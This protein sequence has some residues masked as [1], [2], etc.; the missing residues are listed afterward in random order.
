MFLCAMRIILSPA[1]LMD[2]SVRRPDLTCSTPPF[3]ADAEKLV[4][5]LRKL[6]VL[7]LEEL[8]NISPKIASET[9][10]MLSH[11]KLPHTPENATPAM[12]LFRGEVY[13]GLDA[14][15]LTH[16]D[17]HFAQR[18]LII[19]SGL[20]GVLHALDLVQPYRLM[21]GTS[22]APN[23]RSGSLYTYWGD[24][25]ANYLNKVTAKGETIVN[26]ASEEYF[27]VLPGSV[28]Q[29]PV[30][31]CEFREKK[32]SDTKIV[33]VYAK[34]ARGSMARFIIR[35]RIDTPEELTTFNENGYCYI[36]GMSEENR[37]VY[38]R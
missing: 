4:R 3:L 17:L 10:Q 29:R 30:V 19:L 18:H 6:S 25:L 13:R 34:Q 7:Q 26:L 16:G 5:N 23:A 22:Y 32:G 36:P 31:T 12:F 9:K 1:K 11:W 24:R 14:D 8:M 33:T 28:L 20:Y 21:M 35:N 27:R 38:V 37:M 2:S 15:S